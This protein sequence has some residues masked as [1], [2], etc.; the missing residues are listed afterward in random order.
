[1]VHITVVL[2]DLIRVA[3]KAF[4][5]VALTGLVMTGKLVVTTVVLKAEMKVCAVAA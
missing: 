5:M 2:K 4:P 3:M 1:M